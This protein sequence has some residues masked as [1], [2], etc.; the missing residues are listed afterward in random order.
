MSSAYKRVTE[1]LLINGAIKMQHKHNLLNRVC[2]VNWLKI[3]IID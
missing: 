2:R 3:P 1:I